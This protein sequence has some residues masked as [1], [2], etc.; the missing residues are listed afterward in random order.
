MSGRNFGMHKCRNPARDNPAYFRIAG[1][2][3]GARLT[4]DGSVP[5]RSSRKFWNIC[6]HSFRI[7]RHFSRNFSLRFRRD[8]VEILP[9]SVFKHI[10][11]KLSCPQ[12]SP[13]THVQD[14]ITCAKHTAFRIYSMLPLNKLPRLRYHRNTVRGGI[15]PQKRHMH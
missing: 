13:Q 11:Q 1:A 12:V 15:T 6:A 8:R 7:F 9:K 14:L 3:A 2:G 5:A 10:V 4:P